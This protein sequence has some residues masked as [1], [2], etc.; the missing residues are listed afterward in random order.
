MTA[1]RRWLAVG[2]L[3]L[4]SAGCARKDWVT[5]LLVLTDVTG[6]W[7]GWATF[8]VEGDPGMRPRGPITLVLEQ[9]GPKVIGRFLPLAGGP[10]MQIEG[11]VA[12]EVLTFATGTVSG[13]LKIDGDEM[14]GVVQR[15]EIQG[16]VALIHCP[17]KL[18]L[19]RER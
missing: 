18:E 13:E 19:R 1:T 17:C 5:D 12:G 14:A 8:S 2:L 11:T 4:A 7:Q 16:G 9:K 3:V 10:V 6:T 15:A